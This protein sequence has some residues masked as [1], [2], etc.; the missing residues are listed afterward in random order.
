MP[1]DEAILVSG[2]SEATGWS[3]M[4]NWATNRP[5]DL[6]FVECLLKMRKQ[7]IAQCLQ[8]LDLVTTMDDWLGGAPKIPSR[9][10][11]TSYPVSIEERDYVNG[12]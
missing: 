10:N 3:L 8:T 11:H 4:N 5:R 12:S 2:D 7:F 9:T 6:N 1:A